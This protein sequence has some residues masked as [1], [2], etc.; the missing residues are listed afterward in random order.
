M[1]FREASYN[2]MNNKFKLS[3][4][5]I[6]FNQER[7]IRQALQSIFDQVTDF[8]FDVIVGDDCSTDNTAIIIKEF[9]ERYPDK[10][11]VILQECNTGGSK[12]YNDVHAAA[13]GEYVAHLDGDDV[14]RPG[15]L[16]T[17]VQKLDLMP[18]ISILWHRMSLFSDN[19]PRRDHPVD[20]APY[21]EVKISLDDLMLYGPFGIHSSTMY[22]KN[23]FHLHD[24]SFEGNDWFISAELIGTGY[25]LMMGEVLG[26]Y[27]VY[28]NGISGGA[29][30]NRK[31]REYLCKC[32]LRLL[33][34][35]PEY[36]SVIALRSLFVAFLDVMG[37]H[38][39]F[40]ESLKVFI[41]CRAFPRVFSTFKLVQFYR[42]SKLPSVFK[43][44][45]SSLA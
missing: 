42:H 10:M 33:E 32:Q 8:A 17:Q 18:E 43:R 27:R 15:K 12:N 20:T 39:Y 28:S 4:C 41:K 35:F 31:N 45:N 9:L 34:R 6:T 19:G 24:L 36:K 30:S 2:S 16:Q 29:I 3:V 26:E 40:R 14:M 11:K 38:E 7:Y 1:E 44:A 37:L 13:S 22:R 25:G 21:L 5:V 23:N